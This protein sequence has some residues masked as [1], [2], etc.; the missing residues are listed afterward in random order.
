MK[1]L[2]IFV[3]HEKFPIGFFRVD[4]DAISALKI[5]LAKGQNAVIG[6]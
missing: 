4:D 2:Y 6:D 5:V 3:E 1:K